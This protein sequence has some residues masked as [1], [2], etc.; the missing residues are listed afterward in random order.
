[1]VAPHDTRKTDNDMCISLRGKILRAHEFEHETSLVR[2][3]FQ[4]F[5]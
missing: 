3:Y 5:M 4:T 2:D 1:V